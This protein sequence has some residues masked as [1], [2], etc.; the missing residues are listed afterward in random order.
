MKNNGKSLEKTIRLI[1]ETL[2]DS[3]NTKIFN[4]YKIENES[5]QKRE[6]DIL[7]VSSINDFEI[8][9]AIECKDYNKKVP[10]K[11]IEAFESKCDRI[12]QIN[13]KVF[14][15]TNG[16]QADAINSA[17]YYG[18]ELHT[19]NK[20]K[21][22]DIQSWFPIKQM[23]LQI[24]SKFIAPTLYLDTTQEILDT[25]LKEFNGIVYRENINEPIKIE[26]LLIEAIENN[27]RVIMNL[28]IVEWIKLEETEKDESFP[29]Q[30]KLDFN[31]Y[32]IKSTD[33]EKIKLFGLTSS[34]YGK[35]VKRDATILSGRI[36]KGSKE[37]DITKSI[38]IDVGGNIKSDIIIDKNEELTFF[39]TNEKGESEKLKS[40]LT[41]NTKTKKFSGK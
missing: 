32:Y 13:K 24:E 10:V 37:N 14:V 11:E 6:I 40:L 20:L 23:G 19:A 17:K 3:E 34:V 38:T 26:T 21:K 9:I 8:K 1:Q 27:K 39:A 16:Y 4:N 5:G 7:I 36:V 22:E 12:K 31:D 33:I 15:S 2:K 29:I 28:A 35:F 25:I 18:I 41:Y 30:F